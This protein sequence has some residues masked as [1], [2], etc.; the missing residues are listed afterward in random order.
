M[1]QAIQ[2]R[3]SQEGIAKQVGPLSGGA[4]AGQQNAPTLIALVDQVVQVF[5]RG[6]LQ[7]LQPE[8]IQYQQV[9]TQTGSKTP[10]VTAIRASVEMAQQFVVW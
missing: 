3:R 1:R 6:R 8:V 9:G 7:R 4:I 10:L 2:A 5:W